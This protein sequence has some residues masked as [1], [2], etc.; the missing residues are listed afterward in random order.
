MAKNEKATTEVATV[1]SRVALKNEDLNK[2]DMVAMLNSLERREEITTD[3][4]FEPEPGVEIRAY[5]IGMTTM[6]AKK[7]GDPDVDAVKLLLED[8]T[9]VV[10]ANAMLVS[11]LKHLP[12]PSPV[13][14]ECTGEKQSPKGK[15]KTYKVFNLG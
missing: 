13:Q 2:Q 7:E 4:Y 8:E 15:Y 5:F 11:N 3:G 6:K 10:A 9:T 14:I 1:D 12:I